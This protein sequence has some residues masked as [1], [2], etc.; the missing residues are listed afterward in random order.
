M[1]SN[2]AEPAFSELY[3]AYAAGC[4]DPAFA[5]LV[6]TQA[7]LRPDVRRDIRMSEMIA[8]I[9]F[10]KTEP[11][12]M[13]SDAVDRALDAIDA[14]DSG[15]LPKR[16]VLNGVTEA[17]EELLDL[18]APLRDSALIAAGEAGWK[19]SGPGIRRLALPISEKAE[20]E[21][22]RI[23]PGAVIPRHTHEGSELTLVVAGGFTDESGFFGPGDLSVKGPADTHQPVAD[24][25]G[26]CIVLAVRDGGL[27]F[28][29]VIGIVQRLMG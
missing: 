7:A 10:E 3:S 25:D 11:A 17:L 6:E 24:D 19:F 13:E 2:K 22:Y 27:R 5:L 21:L 23:E 26:P 1:S 15:A 14:L 4:L 16:R 29:G 28:Q 8:A 12:E 18:P 9:N 20:T